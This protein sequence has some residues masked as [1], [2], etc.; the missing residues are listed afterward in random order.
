MSSDRIEGR[1]DDA[2]DFE[3]YLR[4]IRSGTAGSAR[5]AMA[6]LREDRRVR[7]LRPQEPDAEAV[8]EAIVED[9]VDAVRAN[10]ARPDIVARVK[11]RIGM[12]GHVAAVLRRAAGKGGKA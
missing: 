11:E 3:A 12:V 1:I 5:R 8:A 6:A 2:A 9:I 10:V 4:E 7:A